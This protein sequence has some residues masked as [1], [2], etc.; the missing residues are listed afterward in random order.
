MHLKLSDDLYSIIS[1]SNSA[2]EHFIQQKLYQSD[3]NYPVTNWHITMF[4]S[5]KYRKE[6]IKTLTFEINDSQPLRLIMRSLHTLCIAMPC[7]R[8]LLYRGVL[9]KPSNSM[10]VSIR[11]GWSVQRLLGTS[12]RQRLEIITQEI[13]RGCLL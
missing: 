2:T 5:Q 6:L 8:Q 13:V 11:C 10:V 12:Y 1:Y 9:Y 4:G 7:M 3:H